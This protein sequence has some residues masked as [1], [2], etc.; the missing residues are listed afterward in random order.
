MKL[1]GSGAELWFGVMSWIERNNIWLSEE[2]H[3]LVKKRM[4]E[5]SNEI[6]K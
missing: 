4:E 6:K 5:Y 3:A 1:D 2:G